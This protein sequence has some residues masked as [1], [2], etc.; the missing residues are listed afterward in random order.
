MVDEDESPFTAGNGEL[1]LI[2]QEVKGWDAPSTDWGVEAEFDSVPGIT[3]AV[4]NTGPA[5]YPYQARTTISGIPT[6]P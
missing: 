5:A 6:Q 4:D 3:F 2:V 1:E